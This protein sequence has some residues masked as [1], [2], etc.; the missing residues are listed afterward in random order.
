MEKI[1]DGEPYRGPVTKTQ[2]VLEETIKGP[3][4]MG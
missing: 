4:K 3:Y 2:K 1:P